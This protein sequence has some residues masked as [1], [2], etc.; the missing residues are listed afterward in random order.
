MKCLKP[1][2][3][4][5]RLKEQPPCA[6]RAKHTVKIYTTIQKYCGFGIVDV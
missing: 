2:S 5:G 4:L 1:P 3:E 6:L